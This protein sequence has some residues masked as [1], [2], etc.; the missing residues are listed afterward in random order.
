ME[1]WLPHFVDEVQRLLGYSPT[2]ALAYASDIRRFLAYLEQQG[3]E[4]PPASLNADDVLGF[5][6]YEVAEGRSRATVQRRTA[7]LRVLERCLL[8]THRI[9]KPFMPT[10]LLLEETL[11]QSRAPRPTTCL[12]TEDLQRLWQTLLNSPKRQA[13]RDLAL[14]ALL[15]EW[16]FPVSVLLELRLQHV[17]W[18]QQVIWVPSPSGAML[19]WPLNRAALPLKRYLDEG[20]EGL[21]PKEGETHLFISQQGKPLSRQSVWHSLRRWGQKADLETPLTP[22]VLRATAA[23]R[24]LARQVPLKTIGLAL[25]HTNPLSTTLLVRRLHTYCGDTSPAE[26]PT[27]D[28]S[29]E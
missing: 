29:A 22:R 4:V 23:H 18:K 8:L 26:L 21:S 24:L 15:V 10:E 2:T 13:L 1:T 17:D 28:D 5:L 27:L 7:S 12:R 9:E 20:R 11:S 16:G 14:V 19:S 25:G 3:K 6:A